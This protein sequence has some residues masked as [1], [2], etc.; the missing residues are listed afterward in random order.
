MKHTKYLTVFLI[1]TTCLCLS[2]VAQSVAPT[3]GT[4]GGQT[5]CSPVGCQAICNPGCDLNKTCVLGMM[6]ACGVCPS[7]SCVDNSILGLPTTSPSGSNAN[8][9]SSNG[10]DGGMIGGIVGGLVGGGLVLAG[11]FFFLFRHKKQKKHGLPFI[12]SRSHLD[13][14]SSMAMSN[15]G[16]R[17]RT[18]VHPPP[19]PVNGS[20]LSSLSSYQRQQHH[21]DQRQQIRTLTDNNNSHLRPESTSTALTSELG[22]DDDHSSLS[23]LSQR[24]STMVASVV[25]L[26][27]LKQ[28]QQ[29][30][31]AAAQ[32]YQVTRVKPQIMRVNTVRLKDGDSQQVGNPG[33]LSRSG[34]VRTVLT[35]D[36]SISSNLTRSNTAPSRRPFSSNTIGQHRTTMYSTSSTISPESSPTTATAFTPDHLPLPPSSPKRISTPI[37]LAATAATGT[38]V[39]S[40]PFHDR[41]SVIEDNDDNDEQLNSTNTITK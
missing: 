29:Q 16:S 11:A 33:G 18:V 38:S 9:Q 8:D 22:D 24:G 17:P 30:Q 41:H 32:A 3:N 7:S 13:M 23:S 25:G 28:Q 37:S 12:V 15:T 10:P 31:A 34:S 21:L 6:K 1:V 35:R 40:N 4:T 26:A 19:S 27:Q 36:N 39:T 5:N 20:S 2:V 14:T